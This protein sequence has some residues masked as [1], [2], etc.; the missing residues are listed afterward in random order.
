M[1]RYLYPFSLAGSSYSYLECVPGLLLGDKLSTNQMTRK[2]EAIQDIVLLIYQQQKI[3]DKTG[4][5]Y[6]KNILG[7]IFDRNT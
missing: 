6:T 2:K 5:L 7:C 1:V 4:Y 3:L